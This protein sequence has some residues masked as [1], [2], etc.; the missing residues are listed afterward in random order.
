M[1]R[2]R[3]RPHRTLVAEPPAM[4]WDVGQGPALGMNP[5]S[6]SRNPGVPWVTGPPQTASWP[7]LGVLFRADG[8]SGTRAGFEGLGLDRRGRCDHRDDPVHGPTLELEPGLSAN[9]RW[10][11]R[12]RKPHPRDVGGEVGWSASVP[13]VKH[14][15]AGWGLA[16]RQP[17]CHCKRPPRQPLRPLGMAGGEKYALV[18]PNTPVWLCSQTPRH[19]GM[20]A[21]V[22]MCVR[23]RRCSHGLH[24]VPMC[25]TIR[26]DF[27]RTVFNSEA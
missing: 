2:N 6:G 22:F 24:R 17:C 23:G 20:D 11:N 26:L 27:K 10:K 19:P 13:A 21:H 15:A 18:R 5:H 3:N 9:A 8:A 16:G 7:I 12:S 14:E 4:H 1:R 25:D